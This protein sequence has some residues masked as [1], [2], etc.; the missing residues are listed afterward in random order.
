VD[1]SFTEVVPEMIAKSGSGVDILDPSKSSNG[2]GFGLVAADADLVFAQ[3]FHE[4]GVLEL[5]VREFETGEQGIGDKDS[6]SFGWLFL[7]RMV[8]LVIAVFFIGRE[9]H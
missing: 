8:K 5:E 3:V 6:P 9:V 7:D 1:G 4:L 2:K